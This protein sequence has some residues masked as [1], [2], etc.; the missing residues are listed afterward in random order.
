M[1]RDVG[2][3]AKYRL[4][5]GDLRDAINS[6]SYAPGER[7]P[8]ENALMERYGVA[9]MT[10]RQALSVL[11][12]EGLTSTRKGAGVF[13]RDFR[14]I[15]RQGISRLSRDGWG[16][17]RGVWDSDEDR[18]ALTVDKV[19]VRETKASGY[20]AEALG[21]EEGETVITRNRRYLLDGRA[22]LIASSS[23]PASIARGTAIADKDT[24]P[25]GVYAR[26]AELGLAPSRFRE[27]LRSRMPTETETSMLGL[28]AGTPVITIARTAYTAEGTP[29][30]LNEM[31]LD[32]SA[33][34]L[35][36]DFDA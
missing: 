18:R 23:L 27:D 8:G 24:G 29:V 25:G 21:L 15:V 12:N 6:G 32:A 7:L 36:Y 34:V 5:A 19:K 17:G 4:I 30:E 14:P 16:T 31:T 28:D 10:A 13:V 26:L 1:S 20:I 9:R 22:V 33:H 35:R 2:G 11:Q 3:R